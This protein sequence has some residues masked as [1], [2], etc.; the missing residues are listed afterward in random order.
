MK[1]RTLLFLALILMHLNSNA[2]NNSEKLT[3]KTGKPYPVVDSDS[4]YYFVHDDEMLAVKGGNKKFTVQ[5]FNLKS[6]AFINATVFG[7]FEK[8]AKYIALLNCGGRCYYFYSIFDPK[9]LN[10][11]VFA[12]EI[13]FKKGSMNDE[14]KLIL[15]VTGKIVENTMVHEYEDYLAFRKFSIG[16]SQD[17]TKILISYR[18]K[19]ENKMDGKSFDLIGLAVFDNNLTEIWHGEKAMP[20]MEKQM[21]IMKKSVDKKGNVYLVAKVNN[22]NS[23]SDKKSNQGSSKYHLEILQVSKGETEIRKTA[24]DI[25][26]KQINFIDIIEMGEKIA[27]TGYYTTG[28]NFKLTDGI[29]FFTIGKEGTVETTKYFSLA[30]GNLNQNG[31]S[32]SANLVQ[33]ENLKLKGVRLLKDGSTILIGEQYYSA[34]AGSNTNYH[35]DDI[36]IT[37]INSDAS[38]GWIKKLPKK[39]IGSQGQRAMSYFY[40]YNSKSNSHYIIFFDSEKN[41]DLGIND[42]PTEYRDGTGGFLSTYQINQETGD[43]N[44]ATLFDTK[45]VNGLFLTQ[46]QVDNFVTTSDGDYVMEVYKKDKEDILIKLLVRMDN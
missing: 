37:K 26:D 1:I 40:D 19:P 39:Q 6:M 7:A 12:R 45:S 46:F 9:G 18:K 42:S 35:Y 4:K 32:K 44:R 30:E 11:Q 31:S 20:Y 15:T 24:I 23:A 17:S 16:L 34:S 29:F 28:K 8:N 43:A 14:T 13:D 36:L 5:K 2:Q 10:E 38:L 21:D 33:I 3:Y 27:C 22:D 41:K 25:A